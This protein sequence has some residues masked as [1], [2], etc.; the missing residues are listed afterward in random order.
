MEDAQRHK[1]P[2]QAYADKLAS[3][4]VPAVVSVAV[5]TFV[6]WMLFGD[7][8]TFGERFN[9][10]LMSSIAVIVVACPCALGLATPTAVMVGT[11][12]GATQGVLIKGGAVLEHMHTVNTVIFDKTG[13]LTS[14]KATLSDR[15]EYLATDDVIKDNVPTHIPKDKV[16][17]WLAVCAEAQSEHPL[18][19]AIVDAAKESWRNNGHGNDLTGCKEGV[20][21]DDFRVQP[22]RGVECC[23]VKPEWGRRII[24]VGSKEWSKERLDLAHIEEDATGDKDA[25]FLRHQGKIAI[26]LSL[27]EEGS[28]RRRVVGVFGVV[29]PL[30]PEAPSTIA[31]LQKHGIDVWMCT[32]DDIVTALAVGRSLGIPDSNICAGVTPEGKADLVTR[33]QKSTNSGSLPRGRNARLLGSHRG[34]V[35]MVADGV[36]DSIALARSDVG[37]AIGAGREIA[38]EAAD[39]VLVRSNLHDVVVAFHL[40]SVVFRRILLNF[41]LAL[42]YNVLAVPFAAG[43]FDPM[44]DFHLPPALAGFMMACSSISVVTSSLLLRRYQRPIIKDD[45]S[46]EAHKGWLELASNCVGLHRIGLGRG[47]VG[48]ESEETDMV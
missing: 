33:L 13:T 8:I 3:V 29:D 18:A 12:V 37:I 19:Q 10:A 11:G 41:V 9:I 25:D 2:I 43:L 5:L 15:I 40:S 1:A 32:G 36:N 45:G 24:R 26:Y 17:L 23:I 16:V 39:V 47:Y 46:L 27:L 42:C 44:T 21:V 6:G 7:S 14:G 35:A 38:L 31:A 28:K 34:N 4:F 48:C 20:R 22:G 30:K